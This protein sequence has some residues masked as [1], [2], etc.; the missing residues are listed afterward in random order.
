MK[1]SNNATIRD[2]ARRAGVSV[3]TISR[4]LNDTA[5]LA[6]ETARRVKEAMEELSFTPHPVAR[7]LATK[8]TNT[9]GLLLLDIGGNY[10]TPLL[11]GIEAASS[12]AGYDLL[13]HSTRTQQSGNR[14][15]RALTEHNTDG[16]LVFIDALDLPE[17]A[18]LNAIGFPVVMMHQSAPSSLDIPVVTIENQSGAFQVVDHLI[19]VH[20]RK[21]IAFLRGPESNEDSD[22][23]ELGYR[24][25]LKKHGIN[26]DPALIARGGFETEGAYLA[27]KDMLSRNVQFD[28]IFTGDD[29]S[30]IGVLDALKQAGLNVPSDVSIAGFDNSIFSNL[31]TPPLTTVSAPIEDVGRK[32]VSQLIHLIRGEEAEPRIVLPTEMIL[33][34]SCG[35]S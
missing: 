2:V 25:A 14:L 19:T 6:A 12:D 5:P 33:R 24:Q 35:C 8:R 31:L 10:Y 1:T 32:A 29:D 17:L 16:L 11:R 28:A 7:N 20:N 27:V 34:Q 9:L 26:S 18:R 21:R 15:R 13:I 22:A 3:A 30:A 23:R 4:Y